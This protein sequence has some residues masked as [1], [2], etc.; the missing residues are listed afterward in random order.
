MPIEFLVSFIWALSSLTDGGTHGFLLLGRTVRPSQLKIKTIKLHRP[1][2][3][4]SHGG[5]K[6]L[7]V[8][9]ARNLGRLFAFCARSELRLLAARETDAFFAEFGPVFGAKS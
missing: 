5:L 3:V 7:A 9:W 6:A 8:Q 2:E 1:V 4:A